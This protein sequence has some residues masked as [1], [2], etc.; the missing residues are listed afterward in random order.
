MVKNS[1]SYPLPP[2]LQGS[3]V[4]VCLMEAASKARSNPGQA[5]MLGVLA[6]A[7][8]TD[9]RRWKVP[10]ILAPIT[11]RLDYLTYRQA[12]HTADVV[13]TI[14]VN[15]EESVA[16]V[17]GDIARVQREVTRIDTALSHLAASLGVTLPSDAV[18]NGI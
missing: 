11:S 3:A 2:C 18:A 4:A 9:C 10:R 17:R 8:V 16:L 5:A 15:T 6:A 7:L 13:T 1:V 12:D 14:E